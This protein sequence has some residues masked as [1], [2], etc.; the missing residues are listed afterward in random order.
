VA[1]TS[2]ETSVGVAANTPLTRPGVPVGTTPGGRLRGHCRW[3]RIQEIRC[4]TTVISF[5]YYY[6]QPLPRPVN[7]TVGCCHRALV[8]NADGNSIGISIG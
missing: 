4:R 8:M 5:A 3:S 7:G 2:G 6:I 1:I